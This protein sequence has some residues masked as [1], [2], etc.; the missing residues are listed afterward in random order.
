MATDNPHFDSQCPHSVS[1]LRARKDLTAKQK[2]KI[3]GDNAAK[4]SD[5][6]TISRSALHRPCSTILAATPTGLRSPM[7]VFSKSKMEKSL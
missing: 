4:L 6:Q 5:R 2:D 7:T 1:R 3:F